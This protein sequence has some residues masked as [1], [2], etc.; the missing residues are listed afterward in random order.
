VVLTT[1]DQLVEADADKSNDV[2]RVDAE[3]GEAIRVSTNL[4][5]TGGNGPL[6]AGIGGSN[7]H[8]PTTAI[9][10]DGQKIVFTTYEALSPLD[11][12]EEPD[13][14]L[15]TPSRVFLIST[16]SAGFAPRETAIGGFSTPNVAIDGSGQDIYFETTQALTPAD[17]D[18]SVDVYDAR[19]GGGFSFAP[20]P[21]CIGEKCQPDPTPVPPEQA[22]PSAQPGPG[23]PPLPKPCAK[24]KV[25]NK[26]GKCVKKP[27]KHSSKKHHGKKASHKQGGGK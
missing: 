9:S 16:G 8:H 15:W 24:G 1:P 13:V 7:E 19:I 22:P 3:T 10:D 23:N 6:D 17:G 25:R 21:I 26:H 27:K 5:G 11:G 18:T 14:Y 4:V 12:N 2:Y 20:K